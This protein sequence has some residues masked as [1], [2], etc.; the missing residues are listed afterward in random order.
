LGGVQPLDDTLNR[1]CAFPASPVGIGSIERPA[2]GVSPVDAFGHMG[3]SFDEAGQK[4]LVAETVIH[5]NAFA[6]SR[7]LG[8]ADGDDDAVSHSHMGR[9]GTRWIH[10]ED[11]TCS[12]H[13]GVHRRPPWGISTPKEINLFVFILTDWGGGGKRRLS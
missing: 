6:C 7:L 4:D 13:D 9:R 12:I 2:V 10:R 5:R 8:I 1:L 11:A 3:V